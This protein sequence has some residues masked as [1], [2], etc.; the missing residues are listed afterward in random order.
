MDYK[1]KNKVKWG[2]VFSVVPLMALMPARKWIKEEG[3]GY[4]LIKQKNGPT[5]GYSGSSGIK[6]LTIDGLA[7]KDLNR[8]GKLDIYEDWRQPFDKRAKNLAGQLSTDEIAGLMLHSSAN[9][10]PAVSDR[11]NGKSYKE[12]GAQPSDLSDKELKFFKEDNVRHVLVSALESPEIAARWNNNTQAYVEGFHHGIPVNCSTDPRH[13]KRSEDE[14]ISGGGK[15]SLWSNTLGLA[16]TFD[17]TIV[18]RYGKIVAM[19]Y[20]ALGLTTALSPQIDIATDPRWFRDNGTFG[21]SPQLTADMARAYINGLQSSAGDKEI[22]DGWGYESVNA[23]AKHWPGGGSGEG[24]RDAHFGSGK[25]AVF[26]NNNLPLHKIAFTRGAFKLKGKTK[27]VAAVMPYYTISN[28]QGDSVGNSYSSNMIQKQLR[29]DAGFNG[30]VC[31]DWGITSN[32]MHPGLYSGK[33][34]GVEKLSV[35]ERHYKLIKAG[36]DQFGGNSDLS[37]VLQAYAMGV[38]ENGE[39]FMRNRLE[40]SAVRILINSFHLGLFENPY[41]DPVESQRI[42]GNAE[43]MAEG[44]EAQKKSVVMVKNHDHTLPLKQKLKVYIPKRVVPAARAFWGYTIQKKTIEPIRPDIISEYYTVVNSPQEAD[45]AIVFIDSPNSGYGYDRADS[46]KGGNGYFPIS[47]QYNDYTATDAR[48]VSIAGGDPFES[49]KNRS[50]K[51]KSVQT[52]NKSD[53]EMVINTKKDMG[54]KPVIV[55]LSMYIP[56]IVSEFE[57]Y[58]DAIL[59]TFEIQN[60]VV[61]DIVSGKTEPSALLPL[62]MPM[63][64]H[65]VETQAEDTPGDMKC[66]VDAD[67]HTYDFAFGMNFKG[68]IHDSRVKK[69]QYKNT[70]KF[71]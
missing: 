53:M 20:R 51:G 44:Y 38:K 30:L 58:A 59:I 49:F 52:S 68:V 26:P 35:V 27:S 36:V 24:G 6:I 48:A 63:N 7:F 55:A 15:I 19:E 33:P 22:A 31:S 71:N 21:E 43:F 8:N 60:Q 66:Y 56:T 1:I 13:T 70:K 67:G 32:E 23:M 69:Y 45:F 47:L 3:P 42:V 54:K 61:M 46:M 34:W 2:L 12:S 5:L 41:L 10:V 18:E 50:Y 64:M 40:A 57:P 28:G 14:F 29:G 25:Y 62:Q 65:T 11:Y 17:P 16:A 9:A 4:I 37:V 39:Q